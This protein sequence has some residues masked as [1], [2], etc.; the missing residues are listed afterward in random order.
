MKKTLLVLSFL[1]AGTANAE[2][3]TAAVKDLYGKS[4]VYCH[5]ASM[6][7]MPKAHDVAAW[8]ARMAKGM[9][10]LVASVKTGK[11]AMPP[12]GMCM[13]CTDEQYAALI[14]LMASPQ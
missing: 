1:I 4:C 6:P 9:D 12:K 11:G 10:A 5:A 3:D 2:V 8:E 13:T 7:N 14:T